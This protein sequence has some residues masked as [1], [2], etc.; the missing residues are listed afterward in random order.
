MILTVSG[1]LRNSMQETD[2]QAA[3]LATIHPSGSYWRSLQHIGIIKCI[4]KQ[5]QR[6][7][8]NQN[9]LA[10]IECTGKTVAGKTELSEKQLAG[11]VHLA[12][13]VVRKDHSHCHVSR[14]RRRLLNHVAV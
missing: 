2:K 1:R 14:Q 10:N 6:Q 11:V 5:S 4:G 12:G 13:E 9:A 3:V 8:R 7:T